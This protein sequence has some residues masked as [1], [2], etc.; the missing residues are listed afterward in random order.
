LLSDAQRHRPAGNMGAST[1]RRA[2]GDITVSQSCKPPID[3]LFSAAKKLRFPAT[4]TAFLPKINPA[5]G[6][7]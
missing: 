1:L 2:V 3:I 4:C 7:S 6:A 5:D